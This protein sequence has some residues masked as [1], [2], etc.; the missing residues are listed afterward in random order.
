MSL[1]FGLARSTLYKASSRKLLY[2][3][4]VR[5]LT[6]LA[7]GDS[8]HSGDAI[9]RGAALIGGLPVA[10]AWM[11]APIAQQSPARECI[12]IS[13]PCHSSDPQAPPSPDRVRVVARPKSASTMSGYR[14]PEV[15]RRR[16]M[17]CGLTSRWTTGCQPDRFWP[18]RS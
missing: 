6:I 5:S 3:L 17:F 14:C 4:T 11:Q 9:P 12:G 7:L 1:S 2:P 13:G 8:A 16:K 18:V 15:G 10:I